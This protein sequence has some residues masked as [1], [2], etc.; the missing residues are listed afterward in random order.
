MS[1]TFPNVPRYV[2]RS[3]DIGLFERLLREVVWCVVVWWCG[4]VVGLNNK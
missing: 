4:V 2:V 1:S 3:L